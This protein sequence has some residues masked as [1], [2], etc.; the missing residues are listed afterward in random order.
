MLIAK[1][2]DEKSRGGYRKVY[3]LNVRYSLEAG[4]TINPY[5]SEPETTIYPADANINCQTQT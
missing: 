5:C 4:L 2:V 1:A 3:K